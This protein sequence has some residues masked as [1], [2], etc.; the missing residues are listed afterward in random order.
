MRFITWD[1]HGVILGKLL[2]IVIRCDG[3]FALQYHKNLCIRVFVSWRGMTGRFDEV[4]YGD[5]LLTAYNSFYLSL[6]CFSPLIVISGSVA[7]FYPRN[8][9]NK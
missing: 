8:E 9:R 4:L 3:Q 7:I 1:I 6:V 2:L 5:V